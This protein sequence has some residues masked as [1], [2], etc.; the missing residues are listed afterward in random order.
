VRT[1][2]VTLMFLVPATVG[3]AQESS[4]TA[5]TAEVDSVA[6]DF[7]RTKGLPGLAVGVIRQGRPVA[8]RGFGVLRLGSDSAVTAETIFHLASVTKPFVATAVMQLVE[9]GQ[10]DLDAPITGYVPYF[11]IR[12]PLTVGITV[13]QV[14]NHTAGLPDVTDYAWDRPEYDADAL[15]RWI[16]GL[17][18]SSL[19]AAPGER[20][21]YSNIGFELLAELV[22]KV[23]GEV[24]EVYLQR[25]ILTPLGMRHSTLL[26]TDVDSA[27]LAWGHERS[28]SGAVRVSPVYPYNRRHAGSSTLH[29]DVHD[30]LRWALANLRRG[31]LDGQRILSGAAYDQLWTPTRDL[32]TQVRERAQRAG[33]DLP[34]ESFGIG[35]SWFVL[36]HQGRRLINHG[37]GDRGFRSD[38]LLAPDDSAAVVV[39]ANDETAD[40]GALA[41]ELL[42]LALRPTP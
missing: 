24:F 26:M 41:R 33:I 20:W 40:V 8:A 5:F 21:Q 37:G 12:H 3:V 11:R 14:L 16:R 7:M 25:R 38:L 10:V 27:R 39:L 18:D 34:Y 22:A 23:S 28:D 36:G 29:S 1:L 9:K 42:A 35:L 32:T 15:E 30:M 4:P 13:R 31:E 19:I 2:V 6:R 17:A